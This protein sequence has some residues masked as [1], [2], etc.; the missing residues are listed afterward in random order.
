MKTEETQ[1]ADGHKGNFKNKPL[2]T[3]NLEVLLQPDRR[4]RFSLLL[5]FL[6][7]HPSS[8]P[9]L[10]LLPPLFPLPPFYLLIEHR[11]LSTYWWENMRSC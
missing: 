7:S 5:L 4:W 2:L 10:S 6:F 11:A 1:W 9:S 3:D 8:T